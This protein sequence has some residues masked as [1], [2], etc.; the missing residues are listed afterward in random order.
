MNARTIAETIAAEAGGRTL[1]ERYRDMLA[2]ASAIANRMSLTGET[3]ESIV[4]APRQFDAYGRRMPAG[5]SK[6]TGLAEKAWRE[7][8]ANGPVHQGAYYATPGAV[9]NLP[10][11]LTRVD[12]S[13][14]HQYFSDPRN[15][16]IATASG[17]RRPG[18][19][20]VSLPDVAPTPTA[21]PGG[22]GA[23]NYAAP[24]SAARSAV[25]SQSVSRSQQTW[26]RIAPTTPEMMQS[27]GL[28][29]NPGFRPDITAPQGQIGRAS[30]RERVSSPV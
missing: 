11:G 22:L 15:R 20:G 1:K 16:A 26:E 8:Q 9:G 30:C 27:A 19:L 14:A 29:S 3:A 12:A 7:I 21:S 23:A 18:G 6:L 24:V 17:Y 25:P 28:L 4:S 10:S 13:T 2:I 5:T